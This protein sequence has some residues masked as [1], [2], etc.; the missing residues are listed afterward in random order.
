M[1]VISIARDLLTDDAAATPQ[2]LGQD[3]L[4]STLSPDRRLLSIEASRRQD[5]MAGLVGLRPGGEM[6]R[7]MA[8]AMPEEGAGSTR[9]YRLLDDMAG[10]VFMAPAGWYDWVP[11]GP[12]YYDRALGQSPVMDRSVEGVCISFQ[13]GSPALTADGRTNEAIANHPVAPIAFEGAD[14]WGW[15]R[16][17][18]VRGPNQW[19]VRRLDLWQQDGLLQVDSWFQDSAVKRGSTDTRI[20]FHEYGLRATIDPE[21]LILLSIDVQA[22]VLPFTSCLAAP[23]TAR[24]LIGQPVSTFRKLVPVTLP[25]TRGCTHLNDMLRALQDVDTL[26]GSLRAQQTAA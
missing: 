26:A 18:D 2:L 12:A 21:T 16:L 4:L 1:T 6:R 11:G 22:A 9:L 10:A 13:A 7:A 24:H 17:A 15:H 20:L 3:R 8:A 5:A 19:R 14:P 25:G 23:A